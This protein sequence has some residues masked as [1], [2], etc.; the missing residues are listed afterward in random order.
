LEQRFAGVRALNMGVVEIAEKGAQVLERGVELGKKMIIE[1]G[2][3][4][5]VMGCASMAGYQ[6]ELSEKL[7]VPVLDPVTITYKVAEGLTDI[8]TVHSKVGLY[9]APEPKKWV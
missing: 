6:D 2:A 5:I 7:G 4:V 1:D 8:G 9:A 3:E